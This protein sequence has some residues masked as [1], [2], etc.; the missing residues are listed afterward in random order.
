MKKILFLFG[1]LLLFITTI[2]AQNWTQI[3]TNIEGV[4]ADDYF[5]WSVSL[6]SDGSIVAIGTFENNGNTGEV[7]VYQNNLGTWTQIGTDIDKEATDNQFGYSVCLSSDGTIV[8]IGVTKDDGNGTDVGYVR[9]YQNNSGAW[10]QI[11]SDIVG[12][13]I[14]EEI[15]YGFT[16]KSIS[17]SSDGSIVAVGATGDEENGMNAGLVRVY[18]NNS[19]SWI[20]V[21]ADISGE[22]AGDHFGNSVNL[23]ADG[24]IVAIGAI[25]N[26]A[27]ASSAGLVRVYQNNSGIWSQLGQDIEGEAA[28]DWSGFS[29]SLSSDGSTVAIGSPGNL[30]IL[31][32]TPGQVRVYQNISGTWTQIGQDIDGEATYDYSGASVSLSSDG[33]IV[34]I[35]ALGNDVNGSNTGQV[36]VYQNISGTW[37]QIGVDIDGES[38]LSDFGLSVSLSSNGSILA[39]GVPLASLNGDSFVG[40]VSIY[41][42]DYVGIS[43][44]E[45][46]GILIYP[47]PSTGAFT[48]ENAEAYKIT[49]S[50]VT[51]KIIYHGTNGQ[52]YLQTNGMYIINFKSETRN[53]SSKI[54]IE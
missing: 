3:G 9:V 11:G 16:G 31:D 50:D 2:E 10:T 14:D 53:F 19:G 45:E 37:E 23:S 39:I 29:V 26:D 42:N 15:A 35:G 1:F 22:T 20:P 28:D 30:E 44:L 52:V 33:S 6:S 38:A 43:E 8:A 34:A 54:I 17:L 7:R 46:L 27:S 49:I 41:E 18:Q 40:Y 12:G 32:P 36:R 13:A 21:G 51:S 24:S 4:T 5:G 48:I 25:G 47:N